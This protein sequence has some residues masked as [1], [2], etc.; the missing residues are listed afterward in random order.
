MTVDNID[1]DA[2]IKSVQELLAQEP[3]LSPVLRSTLDVL[4][5]VVKL[6]VNRL[7]LNTQH[8]TLNTQ[9]S[10]V[11]IAANHPRPIL[12]VSVIKA[13][14]KATKIAEVNPEESALP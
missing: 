9:H 5:V 11:A 13:P 2:T 10:T 14:K 4:L 3:N 6:L 12:I 1:V 7:T 8:S